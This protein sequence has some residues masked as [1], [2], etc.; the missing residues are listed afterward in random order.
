MRDTKMIVYKRKR[1]HQ[2]NAIMLEQLREELV[3]EHKNFGTYGTG[4]AFRNANEEKNKKEF[5]RNKIVN[6]VPVHINKRLTG[7]AH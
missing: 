3:I 4:A 5:V 7:I 6:A 2:Q 1:K